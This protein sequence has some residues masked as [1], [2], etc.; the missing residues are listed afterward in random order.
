LVGRIWV[1]VRWNFHFARAAL[2]RRQQCRFHRADHGNRPFQSGAGCELRVFSWSADV[3]RLATRPQ[4]SSAA[5]GECRTVDDDGAHAA[6]VGVD[7][8]PISSNRDLASRR[9]AVSNPSLN[10]P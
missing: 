1:D 8:Y 6:D 10:E 3:V 9:S 4:G 5:T 7:S 2:P